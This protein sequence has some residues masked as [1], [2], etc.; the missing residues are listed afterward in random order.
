MFHWCTSVKYRTLLPSGA[1]ARLVHSPASLPDR[2]EDSP[3]ALRNAVQA[4]WSG[5]MLNQ[6]LTCLQRKGLEYMAGRTTDSGVRF[7]IAASIRIENV[8]IWRMRNGKF[9]VFTNS[10]EINVRL[11]SSTLDLL[12]SVYTNSLTMKRSI[13][14]H[15][16]LMDF[17]TDC[18]WAY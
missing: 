1:S 9:F 12:C 18:F 2:Q 5:A 14:T 17:I 16:H 4:G 15:L 13:N 10:L 8:P 6:P 11:F 3:V 7:G